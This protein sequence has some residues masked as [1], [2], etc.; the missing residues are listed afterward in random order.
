MGR[1]EKI[2]EQLAESIIE[3]VHLMYQN[4]TALKFLISLY[5]KLGKEIDRRQNADRDTL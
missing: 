2:G 5:A 3:T 1:P 4:N